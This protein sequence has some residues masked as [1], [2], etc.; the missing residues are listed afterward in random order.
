MRKRILSF[1][2]IILISIS[3]IYASV[4]FSLF[5]SAMGEKSQDVFY[6]GG[7]AGLALQFFDE[8]YLRLEASVVLS[9]MFESVTM[10]VSTETFSIYAPPFDFFFQNPAL[11]SP[12]LTLG[13]E[14]IYRAG[15][16]LKAIFGILNFRDK[17]FEYTFFSPILTFSLE[18]YSFSYG[19]E[20]VRFSYV[21]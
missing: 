10:A 19:F 16:G 5:L 21:F 2:V 8:P 9:P 7:E 13:G 20:V 6:G 17:D 18:D 12:R 14:Y 4:H 11:W 1:L 15:W 3:S